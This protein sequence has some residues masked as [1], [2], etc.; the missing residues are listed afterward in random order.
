MYEILMQR[1]DP[2][3]KEG[4]ILEW[5]KK[6]GDHVQ[7][8]EIVARVEGEKVIFDIEAPQSGVLAKISV[9]KGTS[10]P[11]GQLIAILAEPG[12][13]VPE[14]IETQ[15]EAPL[16]KADKH[17]K[18][19]PAARRTAKEHDVDLTKIKG[20]GPE[21]RIVKRDVLAVIKGI[22]ERAEVVPSPE[23]MEVIPLA[24][25]RKT[26]ADRMTS[27][28]RTIPHVAITMEINMSEALRLRQTIEDIKDTKIPF[29]AFLTKVVANVLKHHPIHNATVD[30]DRIKV[31]KNV[32]I[33]IAVALEKGLIVPVVHNADRKNVIEITSLVNDLI[34]KAKERRLS[35]EEL[36][37]G[38]FT[39]TNLGGFGVDIFTPI[40][41]PPQTAILG[42][43]RIADKPRVANG[44][45]KVLPVMTLT[46]VF[47]HR[48]IDGT[49]A[50]RFLQDIKKL[51]EDPHKLFDELL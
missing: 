31:F 1:L 13:D 6:E 19:S 10:V 11:V 41:N 7:K 20:S 21:G 14:A 38:T 43:G 47:D 45:I 9:K 2:E 18:V 36:K 8:G 39:I 44:Q 5:L 29:T 28:Y 30:G 46:L 48:V 24:G 15:A 26:I 34:K 22:V 23:L 27:S 51:F 37:G 17:L 40:I 35:M 33:G 16:K 3:M 50:A 49:K 42:V 32:N 4:T 12:E 25:I